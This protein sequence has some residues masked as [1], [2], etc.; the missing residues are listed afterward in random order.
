MI[1]RLSYRQCQDAK[2]PV[3]PPL[4]DDEKVAQ[5]ALRYTLEQVVEW[6]EGYRTG[7]NFDCED[8][9]EIPKKDLRKLA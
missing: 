6:L 2:L 9:Y 8:V 4:T 1:K 3:T 7:N 5:E